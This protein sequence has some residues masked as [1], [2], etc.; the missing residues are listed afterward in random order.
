MMA[1][2]KDVSD[3]CET[4]RPLLLNSKVVANTPSQPKQQPENSDQGEG[5][6]GQYSV[7]T[8]I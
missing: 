4:L 7:A 2:L 1:I 3:I 8:H 5:N 6:L